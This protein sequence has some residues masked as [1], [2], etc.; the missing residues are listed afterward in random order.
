MQRPGKAEVTTE[1]LVFPT[2]VNPAET[3]GFLFLDTE[4]L[5]LAHG[6]GLCAS[7]ENI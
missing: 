1:N 6:A 5:G 2:K 4:L 3:L 7:L